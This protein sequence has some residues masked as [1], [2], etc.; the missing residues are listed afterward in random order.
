ML[1]SVIQASE[2]SHHVSLPPD[3]ERT[4]LATGQ[5]ARAPAPQQAA[6]NVLPTGTRLGEFEITGLLGK[7]G[8]GIVYLAWD[9]SLERV[10]ALKE[11][12]PS[13]FASRTAQSQVRVNS[14]HD[15]GTFEAGLRSFVNEARILA[16]F[17]DPSLIKVYRFWEANGTAYMVMPYYQG[18]TL[19]QVLAERATPP[20]EAWLTGLLAPLLD[21]LAVLHQ[22][23]CFHRD[24]SPDNILMLEDGRPL[25]L[26]FGA[27]RRAIGDVAQEFTVIYKQNYAPIEQYADTPGMRQGAW[28]DLFALASV[29]HFAIAGRAPPPAVARVINDPYVPLAERFA[30]RFSTGFLAAIDRTLSVRPEDRPQ[31]AADMRALLRLAGGAAPPT[32]PAAGRRRPY[33]AGA[34]IAAALLAAAVAWP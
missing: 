34:A 28:T 4:V 23:Q 12:M 6:D 8:F 16:Q 32:V 13:A 3:D 11:Y 20:D 21:T 14:E 18:P 29:V 30:D 15:A 10:V 19:K 31:S 2:T 9:H 17:D 27:A 1:S 5:G 24:I 33:L 22:Q 7:G 26:D 25:L